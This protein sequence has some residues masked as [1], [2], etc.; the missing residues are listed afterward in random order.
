[1]DLYNLSYFGYILLAIGLFMFY[2]VFNPLAVAIYY[3]MKYGELCVIKFWP[4][5]GA[6]GYVFLG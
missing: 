3:K 1:M 6:F 5:L 2:K 4:L